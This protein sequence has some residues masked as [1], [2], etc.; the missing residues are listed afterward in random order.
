[1]RVLKVFSK[2]LLLVACCLL[3]SDA[4]KGGMNKGMLF[5]VGGCPSPL[6]GCCTLLEA[7]DI[8]YKKL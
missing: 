6:G 1:M 5:E 3:L 8:R 7:G 4:V 2:I